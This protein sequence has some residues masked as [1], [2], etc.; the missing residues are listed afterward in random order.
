[1]TRA[2]KRDQRLHLSHEVEEL[3]LFAQQQ[4]GAKGLRRVLKE[5]QI[6]AKRMAKPSRNPKF[7]AV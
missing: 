7:Q 4:M 1:M 3:M 5:T 6:L 2:E